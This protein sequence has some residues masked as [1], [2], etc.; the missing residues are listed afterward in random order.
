MTT[1][2]LFDLDRTLIEFD[3]A[4]PGIFERGCERVGV[5]ATDDRLTQFTERH[6][7]HFRALDGDPFLEASADLVAA[8]DLDVNPRRLRDALVAAE[9]EAAWVH[10]EVRATVE[11]L[12]DEHPLGVV[13][14]GYGPVQREKLAA[15]DLARHVDVVVTPTEVGAFKPDPALYEAAAERLAAESFVIVGDSIAGDVVAGNEAGFRTVLYGGTDER[16]DACLA[17]PAEF[18][19]VTS[20]LD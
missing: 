17:G 9:R 8:H 7:A 13:T 11:S 5:E 6:A 12:A 18:G 1:G 16:A 14:G 4:V 15:V 10:D 3:P 20:L 19:R 2:V